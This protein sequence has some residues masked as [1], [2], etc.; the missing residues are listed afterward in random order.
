[1]T[2]TAILVISIMAIYAIAWLL[3]TLYDL[4]KGR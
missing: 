4:L 3:L 2:P 1:M